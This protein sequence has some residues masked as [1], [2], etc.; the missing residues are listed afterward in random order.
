MRAIG[1]IP[2]TL[3]EEM[4][5][6][7]GIVLTR[8]PEGMTAEQAVAQGYILRDTA[9]AP[10][11]DSLFLTKRALEGRAYPFD[12]ARFGLSPVSGEPFNLRTGNVPSSGR[13]EPVFISKDPTPMVKGDTLMVGSLEKPIVA[14]NWGE[15]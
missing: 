15:E 14:G 1:Q 13:N 6:E 2:D 11:L 5:I 3:T 9:M 8:L 10:A 12:P 4:A 7:Q